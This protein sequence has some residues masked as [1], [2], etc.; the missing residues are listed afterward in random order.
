[1]FRVR[2]VRFPVEGLE[3]VVGG[4]GFGVE[5]LGFRVYPGFVEELGEGSQVSIDW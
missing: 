3:L 4:W 1:V 2:D 5:G